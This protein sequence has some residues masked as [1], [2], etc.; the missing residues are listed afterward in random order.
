[1]GNFDEY[2]WGI[3][4]SVITGRSDRT[5]G[6]DALGRG[7]RGTDLHPCFS[8]EWPEIDDADHE[9]VPANA[10]PSKT[11]TMER[12]SGEVTAV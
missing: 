8:E 5:R 4:V 2:Q 1:M 11:V 3:S 7:D 10:S 9:F 6:R 12:S